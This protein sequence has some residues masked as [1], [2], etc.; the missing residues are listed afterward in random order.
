MQA[1]LFR[2]T[3]EMKTGL[4]KKTVSIFTIR[5]HTERVEKMSGNP[6]AWIAAHQSAGVQR[7][8]RE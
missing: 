4:H 5:Q 8:T 3:H 1:S 7:L 2:K 6:L